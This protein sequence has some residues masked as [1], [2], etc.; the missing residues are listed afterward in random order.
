MVTLTEL[1]NIN[2][3][4]F[5]NIKS[6]IKADPESSEKN[7]RKSFALYKYS[8]KAIQMVW[9]TSQSLTIMLA[10]LTLVGGL[11]PAVMAYTGKLII[12]S[13][14]MA[15]KSGVTLEAILSFSEPARLPFLYLILEAFIIISL[16]G[17]RRGLS[18]SQSLLRALLG[19]KVNVMIL[20]KALTLDLA[21]FED[22]EFY[23]KMTK[24]RREA[25]SRPLSLVNRT[26]T[27]IQSIISLVAYGALLIKFSGIAVAILVITSIPSFIAETKFANQAFRL[28]SWRAPESRE[29]I[30]LETLIAREDHA[31]EVKLYQLGKMMLD[32]YKEIFVRLYSE[33]RDLTIKRGLWGYLF[34]LMSS[35]AFYGA[36]AWIVIETVVGKTTLGEMTM[37]L[38]VFRQGQSTLSGA[39]SSV[40]GMYEDNLYLS[41]LYEFLEQKMPDE[42]KK[43]NIINQINLETKLKD[44]LRFENVSFTYPGNAKPALKNVSLHIKPGEKLAI[45]GGN[46]SGKTTLIKL[47]TRLYSPDSGRI[48]LDGQDLEDWDMDTLH[49]R[50]GVIFQNFVHYQFTVG[51]NIGVGD[52]NNM[53][54]EKKWL[55]SSEKGMSLPFIKDMPAGFKTQLG[56]WFKGGQELSLGQWQ[57]VALSRAFMRENA[58]ILVLDEPT[59]AMDAEAEVMIFERFKALTKDQM[60]LLISHRFSTVRMA[61]KIVVMEKGELIESGTHEDLLKENGRY[62]H[63]FHLQAAGYQ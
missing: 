21:H 30:Y 9:E 17:V 6:S 20:E 14:L 45:V 56:N 54:D 12:D 35:I 38:T 48:I 15:S 27:L 13:V 5:A 58:D 49:K 44:G 31:K 43:K 34:S 40:G 24:A 7:L 55:E 29:Q 50:I 3:I 22:S 8:W 51:E 52:V 47:M 4:T 61:D 2:K 53:N 1:K 26:F 46:G 60:V 23:D 62:A 28:F 18:I 25:S 59:S 16:E 42:N 10:I 32:R 33:D 37:Y 19:Q 11:L 39:L 41:S 63:L 57:K 36:Y